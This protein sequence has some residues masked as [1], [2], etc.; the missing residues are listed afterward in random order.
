MKKF[1]FKRSK[2]TENNTI[3]FVIDKT[4]IKMKYNSKYVTKNKYLNYCKR[5]KQKFMLLKY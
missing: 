2:R 5:R 1:D 4:S 3:A